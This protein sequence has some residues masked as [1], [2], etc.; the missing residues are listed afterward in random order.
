MVG[1]F[2]RYAVTSQV[3]LLFRLL[4]LHPYLLH[5]LLPGLPN[6]VQ[7]FLQLH[8]PILDV[9]RLVKDANQ[10]SG[11]L[12]PLLF[13]QVL[14]SLKRIIEDEVVELDA[15]ECNRPEVHDPPVGKGLHKVG[16]QVGEGEG[17]DESER[18]EDLVDDSALASQLN[19]HKLLYV[20]RP[21]YSAGTH[22]YALQEPAKEDDGQLP[23]L[24]EERSRDRNSAYYKKRLS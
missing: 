16:E 4:L 17:K 8:Y 7:Q 21:D 15:Q 2:H 14:G 24:E 6:D 19:R 13:E 12:S 23:G 3:S 18:K 5:L 9:L 1:C 11:L 10:L 20:G 22:R